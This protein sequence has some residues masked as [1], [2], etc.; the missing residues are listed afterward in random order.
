MKNR[1]FK[2]NTRV[3]R[4]PGDMGWHFVTVD[5]SISNKIRKVYTKGFVKI[6]AQIGKTSWDTSLFP[7]KQS[8]SYLLSIKASVRKKEDILEGDMVRI[9]FKTI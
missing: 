9:V 8:E 2:I 3:W 6:K 1:E 4:W 7:H 5:K